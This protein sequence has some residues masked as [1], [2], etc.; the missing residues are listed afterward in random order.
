MLAP[1]VVTAQDDARGWNWYVSPTGSK[2]WVWPANGNPSFND[3]GAA[4]TILPN[5]RTFS[6]M[7]LI[8]DSRMRVRI[9]D[10]RQQR[11]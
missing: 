6:T 9:L 3:S 8:Y 7:L 11:E 4:P 5:E 2:D 10:T 1:V